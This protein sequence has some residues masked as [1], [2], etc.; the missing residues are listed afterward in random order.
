MRSLFAIPAA[1]AACIYLTAPPAAADW[2]TNPKVAEHYIDPDACAWGM[3]PA[4]FEVVP[5]SG[6]VAA[7]HIDQNSSA[8]L[9]VERL[10]G[11][12]DPVGPPHL[13]AAN[14][15]DPQDFAVCSLG[16]NRF[17]VAYQVRPQPTATYANL[18]LRILRLNG[19]T[20]VDTIQAVT[21]ADM[22]LGG[23]V[24]QVA[25]S[26]RPASNGVVLAWNEGLGLSGGSTV[27]LSLRAQGV[28]APAGSSTGTLLFPNSANGALVEFD[29]Y[30]NSTVYSP[31]WL[32]RPIVL[33]DSSSGYPIVIYSRDEN[34]VPFNNNPG[35]LHAAK[36]RNDNTGTLEWGGPSSPLKIDGQ[37]DPAFACRATADES[38]GAWVAFSTTEVAHN[39]TDVI[40]AHVDSFGIQSVNRVT[41]VGNPSVPPRCLALVDAPNGDVIVT[42]RG[43]YQ[44]LAQ[45]YNIASSSSTP[46]AQWPNFPIVAPV[47]LGTGALDGF[48]AADGCLG[49]Q[50]CQGCA[51]IASTAGGNQSRDAKLS[52]LNLSDG[53]RCAQWPIADPVANNTEMGDAPRQPRVFASGAGF[54]PGVIVSWYDSNSQTGDSGIYAERFRCTDGKAGAIKMTGR[55]FGIPDTVSDCVWLHRAADGS[56]VDVAP[57]LGDG[58]VFTGD[59]DF[60]NVVDM[61]QVDQELWTVDSLSDEIAR[62]DLYGNH[63]GTIASA[64]GVPS[65]ARGAAYLWGTV[66]VTDSGVQDSLVHFDTNGNRVGETPL[67]FGSS[68]YGVCA[69]PNS[70]RLLVTH[71]SAVNNIE[72]FYSQV[73]G[74]AL[75]HASN[76][77]NDVN[78]PRQIHCTPGGNVL[79]AGGGVPRGIYEYDGAGALVSAY[80]AG[81][82]GCYGVAQLENGRLLIT[83]TTGIRTFDP[84]TGVSTLLFAGAGFRSIAKLSIDDFSTTYCTAGTSSNGCT[85]AISATGTPSASAASGYN[86]AVAGLEGN[87]LG[88]LFYG[89]SGRIS[90][91]WGSSFLCVRSPTQRMTTQ[92][93]GGVVGQCNGAYVEDWIA[94]AT[95]HPGALGT[96]LTAGTLVN[97]QAWYRDPP[98]PKTTNLSDALEFT[99]IP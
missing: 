67:S 52:A 37:Y 22:H 41:G 47:V 46:L 27:H 82:S 34:G 2:K 93:S 99:L 86:I 15:V 87:R 75:F 3:L 76:G 45:K 74:S 88:L 40:L 31:C 85:P 64:Q 94:F 60:Q 81:M 56:R 70:G 35:H 5:L 49:G 44:L 30:W 96:P 63:V 36:F 25:M 28:V 21:V 66:Y 12:G 83:D 32:P 7:I 26:P 13:L 72:V 78:V 92:N 11:A 79:V 4:K 53:S 68:P 59:Y 14:I 10:N 6:G 38:G 55:F 91:P 18:I 19:S 89:V 54:N 73:G 61:V 71:D 23:W 39:R 24:S 33:A 95:S 50:V 8:D 42:Y 77:V 62:F 65:I 17:A 57:F 97:V 51:Y 69:D 43:S 80:S 48:D 29:Y 9:V 90:S 84:S 1:L 98:A 16:A 20:W 58:G